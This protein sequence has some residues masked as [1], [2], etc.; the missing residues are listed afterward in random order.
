MRGENLKGW[1]RL[2]IE[3]PLG[4]EGCYITKVGRRWAGERGLL[5]LVCVRMCVGNE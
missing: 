5:G 3:G 4:F 2:W 1:L